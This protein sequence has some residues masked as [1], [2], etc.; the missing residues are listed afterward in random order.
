MKQSICKEYGMSENLL[1]NA[2]LI[3]LNWIDA[4]TTSSL[5]TSDH[6]MVGVWKLDLDL[7]GTMWWMQITL[8]FNR[9]VKCKFLYKNL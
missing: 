5:S 4:K 1:I 3:L 2:I 6:G 9:N 7:Y 8:A